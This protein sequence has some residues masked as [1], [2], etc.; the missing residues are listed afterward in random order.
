ME[1]FYGIENIDLPLAKTVL[2]LGNFD[3]VHIGHQKIFRRLVQRAEERDCHSVVLTF[4]PHPSSL[5]YPEEPIPLIIP[6]ERRLELIAELGIS[7]A[8]CLKFSLEF[9]QMEAKEFLE[10]ILWDKL[11]PDL[12]MVGK[13]FLFG[14]ARQGTSELIRATGERL[15]FELEVVDPVYRGET[16]V[17]SS[18][19]RQL[20]ADGK[21]EETAQMQ[22]RAFE[23][24]GRVAAGRR[25]GRELGFPTAN[26]QCLNELHPRNGIYACL[27]QVEGQLYQA[28]VNVGTAPTVGG[29]EPTVE[30]FLL[31]YQGD[32][33]GKEVKLLFHHWLREER[34]FETLLALSAQIGKDVAKTRALLGGLRQ[35]V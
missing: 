17:S 33:Y 25:L 6:L 5:V 27:A 19:I 24:S 18:A 29:T 8:V 28:A 32:L 30:A 21:M 9:S 31:D 20:V 35:R 11:H 4:Y 12:V 22:G 23:L 34:K 1:I 15:G 2:T 14:K 26:L 10:D 3:G 13:N 7:V 16:M